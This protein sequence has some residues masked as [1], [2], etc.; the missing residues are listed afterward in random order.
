MKNGSLVYQLMQ[1]VTPMIRFGESRREEKRKER[2]RCKETGEIWNPTRTSGIFESDTL[3]T[4]LKQCC[5]FLRWIKDKYKV[6]DIT[7]VTKEMAIEYLAYRRDRG[8]SAWTLQT[9]KSAINKIFRFKINVG[10]KDI[11]LPRRKKEDVV[12]S[13]VPRAHD[14]KINRDNYMDLITFLHATGLRRNEVKKLKKKNIKRI[15]GVYNVI[16]LPK[17]AGGA[18]NGRGR[19][20]ESLKSM[21][22]EIDDVIRN[23]KKNNSEYMFP[24]IPSKLDIHELR[25]YYANDKY[26]EVVEELPQAKASDLYITKDKQVY[27]K[28]ALKR[29]SKNMGHNRIYVIVNSYSYIKRR[30]WEKS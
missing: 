27:D 21:Q 3:K 18:K 19:V 10:N 14:K 23:A 25:A 26:D 15:N 24:K 16:V 13:R 8:D 29:V 20:V 2:E 1:I 5:I 4:Y 30:T 9:I 6:K 7:K 17:A 22:G 12:R 11:D 28:R